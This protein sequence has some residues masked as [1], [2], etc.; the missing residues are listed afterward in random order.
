MVNGGPT[1]PQPGY[2]EGARLLCREH[3]AL[4]ICDEVITGFRAG[5]RGAQGRYGVTA[6]LTHHEIDFAALDQEAARQH[7]IPLRDQPR[8]RDPLGSQPKNMGAA[9]CRNIS[10]PHRPQR[11]S[12]ANCKARP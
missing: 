9:P 5:L 7:A 6:D 2:L 4:F 10:G 1:E 8:R 11:R 12:P 3:G